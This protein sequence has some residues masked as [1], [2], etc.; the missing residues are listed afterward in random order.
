MLTVDALNIDAYRLIVFPNTLRKIRKDK[1]FHTLLAL[2]KTIQTIPYIRLS[3]IERGEVIPN[4]AELNTIGTV[5][6]IDPTDLLIDIDAPDFD[7]AHWAAALLDWQPVDARADQFAVLLGAAVRVVRTTNP[8]LTIAEID[9]QFGIA[10]VI[11]SRIEHALKPLERWNAATIKG[12]CELFAVKDEQALRI[13]VLA[14]ADAGQLAG[15]VEAIAHPTVRESKTRSSVAQLHDVLTGKGSKGPRMRGP[16]GRRPKAPAPMTPAETAAS[17]P[18][19]VPATAPITKAGPPASPDLATVRLVPVFGTP[20]N[21][22]LIARISLD[23]LVEAPQ[24]AGPNAFGLRVCRST[25]G[26]GL[27][28]TATVIVDPDRFPSAGGLA[29]IEEEEGLR[30]VAV[31]FDRHG[32]MMGYSESPNREILIDGYDPARIATVIGAIM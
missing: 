31:T 22:G 7:I 11:L 30:L 24:L 32:R 15:A 10:P 17:L 13:A 19:S 12:L 8:N 1:G 2:S 25:L 6:G 29:V 23:C 26:L 21:E 4:V 18:T 14:M 16:R 3:K 9:R 28:A 5:L 20:L 27:P